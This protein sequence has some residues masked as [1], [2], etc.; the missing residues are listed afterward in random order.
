VRDLLAPA[1]AP[2]IASLQRPG[3]LLVFDFDGTLAPLVRARGA[4]QLG[5]AT[6]R[7]LTRVA[8]ALP[9]AVLSGRAAPD[10]AAKVAGVPVRWAVGGHGAEWPGE[11]PPRGFV[12]RVAG[13]RRVLDGRLAGLDG[14]DV[15]DKEVSLSIHWRAARDA[16]AA[17]A[18]VERAASGLP[19]AR[20]V[21][22]KL[23]L[24]VVPAEAP[25]KGDALARLVAES[26]C[27][28]VLFVGD[29][30][31]DEAGF[32]ARLP[33]PSVMV[34]V[35]RSEASAAPWYLGRRADVDRLLGRLAAH[36]HQGP[37]A[38]GPVLEFMRTLWALEHGLN[39]RSKEMHRLFGVTG[40][41]RLVV[42]VVARVGP[43]TPGRLAKVLH[44]HPASVT[45]LARAL[46]R[47]GLLRRRCDPLDRRR[48]LLELGPGAARVERLE[49]G[50][51]EEAVRAALEQ[52]T[53]AD[54][55][56]AR[57]VVEAIAAGLLRAPGRRAT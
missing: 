20:L 9:T 43:V 40:P 39:R 12:R 29:D 17:G 54:V 51:I 16:A 4:A 23:V 33:V 32:R 41:Q 46:E 38:L 7:A 14:V 50:T 55:A 3:T 28:R 35:G 45:R 10:L 49:A 27:E 56:A 21:G 2:V 31:T 19:G 8:E 1:A 5:A 18:A 24:N 53:P 25:D 57:R 15:E 42:R 37:G 34:R 26:G 6:R 13:W 44:L 48:L 47:R 52:A 30:V 36:S 11:P 22:G